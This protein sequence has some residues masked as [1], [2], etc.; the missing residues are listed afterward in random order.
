MDVDPDQ[1][2]AELGV[3]LPEPP[4]AVGAYLP[5]VVSRGTIVTSGQL[6]WRDGRIAYAGR[7][8]AEFGEDEG[9]AAARQ[10]AIN[11]LAQL[12][13]AAGGE[14]TRIRRI[15]RLEGFVH[16]APGFRGHPRVLDGA[17]DLINDV[18][19]DRGRHVRVALGI[20]EMPLDAAV[21]ICVHAELADAADGRP[22]VPA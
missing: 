2:L 4:P 3:V 6:P 12:R 15:V 8:G 21:Q 5:W 11:A 20:T 17:S 22:D 19:G 1:R 18:F 7:L 14:L 16:C 13:D 9:Y 10:C